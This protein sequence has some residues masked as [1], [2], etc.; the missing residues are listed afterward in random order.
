MLKSIGVRFLDGFLIFLPVILSYLL[1]GALFDILIGLTVPL[2][3]LMPGILLPN[4]WE[5]RVAAAGLFV[6]IC[7]VI[8]FLAGS[9]VGQGIGGW[10]ERVIL[11]RFA[12]YAVLRNF[13]R[14][15]FT[16]DTPEGLQPALLNVDDG[17]QQPVFVVEEHADGRLT[18][19]V[20][21]GAMPGVG[22]VQIVRPDRVERLDAAML[23]ALGCLFNWGD[24]TEAFIK[25]GRKGAVGV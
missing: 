16:T 15:L 10:I 14:R 12:P 20:P 11:T 9:R 3:D 5:Q 17:R 1:V 24:G 2:T 22:H 19:F 8:G 23:D 21:F 7:L 25:K 4:F 18:L 13:A 6:V